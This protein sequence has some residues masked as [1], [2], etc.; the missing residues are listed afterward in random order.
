MSSLLLALPAP[1]ADN[2]LHSV[3]AE[4]SAEIGSSW[5]MRRGASV[6]TQTNGTWW[7][8]RCAALSMAALAIALPAY[9]LD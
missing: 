4:L 9:G 1:T 7:A 6:M 2:G 5:E 3:L 8:A